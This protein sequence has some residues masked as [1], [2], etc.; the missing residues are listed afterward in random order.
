MPNKVVIGVGGSGQHVVHAYLRML[1]MTNVAPNEVPHIYIIDADAKEQAGAA[2]DTTLC[3]D[4]RG[5]HEHLVSP[6]SDQERSHFALIRPYFQEHEDS[7][8]GTAEQSLSLAKAEKDLVDI[9]LTDDPSDG[10]HAWA[11]DRAVELK[12]GMMANPKVGAISF[13]FKTQRVSDHQ[14]RNVNFGTLL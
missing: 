9:F 13:A 3:P 11:N 4:I 8:P 12:E 10:S 5:L 2:D 1:A 7:L 14:S 6:L